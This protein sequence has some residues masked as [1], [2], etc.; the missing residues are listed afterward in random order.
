MAT[1]PAVPCA[2]ISTSCSRPANTAL[3]TGPD[4]WI[5][6][7]TYSNDHLFR[8]D[9]CEACPVIEDLGPGLGDQPAAL[10]RCLVPD[11]SGNLYYLA[12]TVAGQRPSTVLVR[13]QVASNT[14]DVVG[15][16]E[17][18]EQSYFTWR[19]VCGHDGTLYLATIG[20][21]PCCLL[22]YRP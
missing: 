11:R 5:Y 20:R 3:A 15:R 2:A 17:L 14:R 18:G 16:M 12:Q 7:L 4:G 6:G 22:V 13:Y 19:G 21:V 8:F 9:P 1:T 10:L